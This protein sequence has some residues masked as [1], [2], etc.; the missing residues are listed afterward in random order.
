MAS[1]T[2]LPNSLGKY[3]NDGTIDLDTDIIQCA[4]VKWDTEFARCST[5]WV[6]NTAKSVGDLVIPSSGDN[7]HAYYCIV[8]GTTAVSPEPSWPKDGSSF[9]DGSVTWIDAGANIDITQTVWIEGASVWQASH[10]YALDDL[11]RPTGPNANGHY[12]K[13]T[14]DAGSSG[15]TEPTWPT[16]S[17]VT[18]VDGGITWTEQGVNFAAN[19]VVGTAYTDKGVTL[20]GKTMS[21]SGLTA[22][23]DADD[24]A[25]DASTITARIAVLW[26]DGTANGIVNPQIQMILLDDHPADVQS[27]SSQFS[28]LWNNAGII[29]WKPS[30]AC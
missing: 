25:W 26:K 30:Y 19:E 18:V 7:G 12:Y 29:N 4:L 16:G 2:V 3:L 27:I 24:V 5:G 15:A 9:V 14:T 8:S 13:V 10:D 22:K 11:C 21:Y 1:V 20:A 28:I 23:F 6:G 17:G